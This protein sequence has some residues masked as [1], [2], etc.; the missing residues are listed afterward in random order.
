MFICREGVIKMTG[1]EL[2]SKELSSESVLSLKLV[3]GNLELV[4]SYDGKGVDSSLSVKVD[5]GYFMDKLA[6]AIPGDIDDAVLNIMKAA[7][8]TAS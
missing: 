7:L 2:T 5:S 6:E 3:E 1:K 4:I 8:K